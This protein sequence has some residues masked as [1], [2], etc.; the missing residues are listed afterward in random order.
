VRY[1][2]Y[3]IIPLPLFGWVLQSHPFADFVDFLR[4]VVA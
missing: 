1:G 2:C 3:Y 4:V